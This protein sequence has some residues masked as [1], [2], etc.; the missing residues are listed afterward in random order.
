MS[1]QKQRL[2]WST[3]DLRKRKPWALAMWRFTSSGP[4]STVPVLFSIPHHTELLFPAPILRKS[5]QC[6]RGNVVRAKYASGPPAGRPSG[7]NIPV[8]LFPCA[9]PTRPLKLEPWLVHCLW[10][11]RH[12]CDRCRVRLKMAEG[13]RCLDCDNS[14]PSTQQVNHQRL[15]PSCS[16]PKKQYMM[17]CHLHH[18]LQ[19]S[20]NC[21]I[22]QPVSQPLVRSGAVN[23]ILQ[24]PLACPALACQ[25]HSHFFFFSSSSAPLPRYLSL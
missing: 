8:L 15:L 14:V 23:S 9:D 4:L 12:D 16:P 10:K 25:H 20:R 7:V 18:S 2:R 22:S 1:Y 3:E 11:S 24:A 13:P 17:P 19:C 21:P 6:I 5:P